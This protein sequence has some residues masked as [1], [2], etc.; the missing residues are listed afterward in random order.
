[1]KF[2][3]KL[4]KIAFFSLAKRVKFFPLRGRTLIN[5]LSFEEEQWHLGTEE[6]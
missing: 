5:L 1:M 2:L 6:V 3:P 4:P